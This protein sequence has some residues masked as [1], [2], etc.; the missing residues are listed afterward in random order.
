MRGCLVIAVLLSVSI[1]RAD[2]TEQ[3]R[4]LFDSGTKHFDLAEYSEAL[5]DFKNGF[6]KKEDP[7]FLFNIAQCYRLLGKTEDALHFYRSYLRRLP[8]APNRDQVERRI[9]ALQ[10][11]L[12]APPPA[13]TTAPPPAT[14][15]PAPAPS[16]PAANAVA[17][18]PLEAHATAP[19]RKPL[20]RR[21]WLWTGAAAVVAVGL[22]VGLGVGLSRSP[23]GSTFPQV[24]F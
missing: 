16:P 6:R 11:S 9:A 24:Q 5:D 1:A 13:T 15:E 8:D 20:Y 17:P 12:S 3:A 10:Q 22:G 14:A 18:E 19:E 7:V 4:R 2:E 21:W 23:S